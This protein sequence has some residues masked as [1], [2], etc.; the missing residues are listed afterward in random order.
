MPWV[1]LSSQRHVSEHKQAKILWEII[2]Q[3][4]AG[5]ITH[6]GVY[7][8]YFMAYSCSRK[9]FLWEGIADCYSEVAWGK[10][11]ITK[12]ALLN[13]ILPNTRPLLCKWCCSL[14]DPNIIVIIPLAPKP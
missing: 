4:S 14:A 5:D 3:S 11:C 13:F 8:H 6:Q 9:A 12:L 1:L 2:H 10:Y 7:Y